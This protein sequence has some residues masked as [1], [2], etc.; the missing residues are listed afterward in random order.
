ME[1]VDPMTRDACNDAFSTYEE[2][3]PDDDRRRPGVVPGDYCHKITYKRILIRV[4][5]AAVLL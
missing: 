1:R 4:R 5:G 2:L 3:Q